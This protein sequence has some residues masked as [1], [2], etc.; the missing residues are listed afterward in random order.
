MNRRTQ[1]RPNRLGWNP[2]GI[3][4]WRGQRGVVEWIGINLRI[5]LGN[6]HSVFLR[7]FRPFTAI[8]LRVGSMRRQMAAAR[9]ITLTSVVKDSITTSPLYFTSFN[10]LAIGFQSM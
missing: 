5:W 2:F 9:A 7:N 3:L 8:S 1:F 10:A 6:F 4:N